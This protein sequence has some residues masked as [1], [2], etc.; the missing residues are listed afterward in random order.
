MMFSPDALAK[1]AASAAEFNLLANPEIEGKYALRVEEFE[2]TE[3]VLGFLPDWAT[4]LL[5]PGSKFERHQF[6]DGTVI[7]KLLDDQNRVID[8]KKL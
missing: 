8:A 7:V 2:L 5:K 6:P 1:L 3:E 4:T